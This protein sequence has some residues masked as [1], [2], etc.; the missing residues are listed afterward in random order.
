ME[1]K[2][3]MELR[4][5]EDEYD[6]LSRKENRTALEDFDLVLIGECISMDI[7][8]ETEH[9]IYFEDDP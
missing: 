6:K 1:N 2:R 9:P 8:Y 5:L 4:K 3:R 7:D